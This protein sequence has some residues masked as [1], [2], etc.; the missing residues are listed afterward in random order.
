[1]TENTSKKAV[2]RRAVAGGIAWSV[3]VVALAA[4][5]PASAVSPLIDVQLS[6]GNA[7]KYPGSSTGHGIKD[8]YRFPL[9]I[10]NITGERVCVSITGGSIDFDDD[11]LPAITTVGTSWWIVPPT[12]RGGAGT[13]APAQVCLEPGESQTYYF[14]LNNTDN[15]ANES[16][17]ASGTFLA[18]GQTT[19]R[20]ATVTSTVHFPDVPPCADTLGG[21]T[22]TATETPAASAS[23]APAEAASPAASAVAETSASG[24][25]VESVASEPA[26]PEVV[27]PDATE[28]AA[29][30]EV[31]SE[32]A[33]P[34]VVDTA[35]P[36]AAP[37]P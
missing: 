32:A 5:A 9:T 27:A 8:G 35:A 31:A 16:G 24:A 10:K 15:S 19:G 20:Q 37:Q 23:A 29:P 7:C 25:P 3:P 14:I 26:A 1:M 4:A 34:A 28:A 2:S 22:S 21:S 11:R 36:E 17:V 12:K 33:A 6:N 30:A 13:L 18:T